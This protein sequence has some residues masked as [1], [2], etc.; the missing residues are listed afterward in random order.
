[1]PKIAITGAPGAGKTTLSEKLGESRWRMVRHCDELK[2][3]PW[4][5]QS[6]K[7]AGWFDDPASFIVEGTTVPRALRKWLADHPAGKPCD[8]VYWLEPR[9][10]L[11]GGKLSMAKGAETVFREIL[12]E[13]IARGVDVRD[14]SEIE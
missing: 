10:E 3:L 7:I 13:L 1:M 14:G 2:T 5:E 4:S 8:V 12:P 9:S 6:E 11:T